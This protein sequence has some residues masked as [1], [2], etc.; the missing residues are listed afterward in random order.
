MLLEVEL[1]GGRPPHRP[2]QLTLTQL[3]ETES[4]PGSFSQTDAAAGFL[5]S[6]SYEV[7]S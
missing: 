6:S 1:E 2:C 5:S 3:A 4:R 7:Y